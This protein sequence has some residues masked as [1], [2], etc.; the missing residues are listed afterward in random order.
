MDKGLEWVMEIFASRGTKELANITV[1]VKKLYVS[2][3]G[4]VVLRLW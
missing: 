2:M 4:M 3:V 1:V